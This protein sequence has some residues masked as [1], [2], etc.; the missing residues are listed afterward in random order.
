MTALKVAS[1]RN[2]YIHL[3]YDWRQ[4]SGVGSN[5]PLEIRFKEQKNMILCVCMCL[6]VVRLFE[7]RVCLCVCVCVVGGL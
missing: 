3:C 1:N 6:H 4:Y 7:R 5:F 2:L